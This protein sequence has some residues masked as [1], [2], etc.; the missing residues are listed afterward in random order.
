MLR[1][2]LLWLSEQEQAFRFIKGN[3]LARRLASRFVAGNTSTEA[4]EVIRKL[5][6]HGVTA[7]VDLLGESVWRPERRWMTSWSRRLRCAARPA[8]AF[9]RCGTTT[10]S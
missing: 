10:S 8:V 6:G 2:G 4:L 7:T 1:A 9:W 5:A 3:G